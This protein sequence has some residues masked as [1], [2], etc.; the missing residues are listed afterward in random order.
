MNL[1][2]HYE[3]RAITPVV[4]S[5]DRRWDKMDQSPV[6]SQKSNEFESML[7][8][9]QSRR[10]ELI[11]SHFA[12][13]SL[14][15]RQDVAKISVGLRSD[16]QQE[17]GERATRLESDIQSSNEA[18]ARKQ[19]D[20]YDLLIDMKAKMG[21]LDSKI[22]ASKDDIMEKIKALD[23]K[24]EGINGAITQIKLTDSKIKASK[25]DFM[26]K[27]R[28][29]DSKMEEINGAKTQIKLTDSKIKASKDDFM[30]KIK[31]LDL[32]MEEIKVV[33]TE[34][35]ANTD[36]SKVAWR[37]LRDNIVY[38]TFALVFQGLLILIGPRG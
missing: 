1:I 8:E 22:K 10:R 18:S 4:A 11:A 34:I 28:A 30:E 33:K 27:I 32:K 3:A 9:F 36:P 12:G 25:D 14:E 21:A 38:G 7:E 23:L 29:L 2:D 15:L 37:Q 26:E 19:S 6:I 35:Q 24:M 17:I 20:I 16:M 31:A 13:L 5:E